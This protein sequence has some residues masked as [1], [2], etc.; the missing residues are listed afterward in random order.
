MVRVLR[1]GKD[2]KELAFGPPTTV[3]AITRTAILTEEAPIWIH[4]SRVKRI[5]EVSS[6]V[7]NED[8]ERSSEEALPQA[9][10][11]DPTIF[12][13]ICLSAADY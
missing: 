10:D 7:S 9:E 1:K 8:K 12:W 11:E 2:P 13:E 5:P 6:P 4:A 3:V